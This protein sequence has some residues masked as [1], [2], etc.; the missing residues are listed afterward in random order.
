MIWRVVF[1]RRVVQE[2]LPE[3]PAVD[4]RRILKAIERKLTVGPDSYGEPLRRE[5]FGYW[6]LRVGDHRVIYRIEKD[7]VA[8]LIL[9]IGMRKDGSVYAEIIKRMKKAG[10]GA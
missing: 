5:L 1:H 8:V 4:R 6:K 10:T 9:K 7:V 3:L 2:D